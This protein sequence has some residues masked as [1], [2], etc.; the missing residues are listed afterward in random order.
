MNTSA[1]V[2]CF[3][4]SDGFSA[5]HG[6]ATDQS[7]KG[8]SRITDFTQAAAR[9]IATGHTAILSRLAAPASS[10]RCAGGTSVLR[11]FGSQQ[12][13]HRPQKLA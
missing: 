12:F 6:R 8:T 2:P 5:L 3:S 9:V 4:K 7:G 13:R 11:W 10:R 1:V